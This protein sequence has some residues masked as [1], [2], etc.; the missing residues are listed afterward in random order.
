MQI[1]VVSS[2]P[3]EVETDV[4][5]LPI[6]TDESLDEPL[7]EIDRRLGGDLAEYRRV[8]ELRGRAHD[9]ALLRGTE[10]GADFVLGMGIGDP[11][12]F[13]RLAAVRF[14]AAVERRLAGR[15]VRRLAVLL[16]SSLARGNG[17]GA[18]AFAAGQQRH[19]PGSAGR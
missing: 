16:P 3:W 11:A 19:Q 13:D 10:M 14:G 5:A 9:G 4:L 12:A 8:G 15:Q 17:S 2:E 18:A 7:A 6:V 1:R